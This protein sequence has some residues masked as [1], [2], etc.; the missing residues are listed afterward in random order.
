M[1]LFADSP[2]SMGGVGFHGFVLSGLRYF[3]LALVLF[4][5]LLFS[6]PPV[7]L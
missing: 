1:Q 5:A 2:F 3:T 6:Q 4:F 7:L